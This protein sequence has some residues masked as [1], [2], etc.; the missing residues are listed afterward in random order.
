MQTTVLFG[1]KFNGI[2]WKQEK[3]NVNDL[4]AKFKK[5]RILKDKAKADWIV[6]ASAKSSSRNFESIS[7]FYGMIIDFD[8]TTYTIDELSKVVKMWSHMIHST[9]SHRKARANNY[10]LFIPFKKPISKEKYIKV[11]RYIVSLFPDDSN[12]DACSVKSLQIMYMPS[13]PEKSKDL[14]EIKIR[15]RPVYFEITAEIQFELDEMGD[16]DLGHDDPFDPTDAPEQGERNEFFT[17]FAGRCV[18]IGMSKSQTLSITKGYN[19]TID[20][21]LSNRDIMV[22]VRS[23]Y[24]THKMKSKDSGWGFDELEERIG[25]VKDY[26]KAVE[27]VARSFGKLKHLEIQQLI[28]VI[29][30]KFDEDRSVVKADLNVEVGLSDDLDQW[31]YVMKDN[32]MYNSRICD[33]VKVESF[34]N[35]TGGTPKDF[36]EMISTGS[37]Q[38]ADKFQFNPSEDL[39][40]QSIEVTYV[41][42]YQQVDITPQ[43][44]DVTV[45]L[46]FFEYMFD[47]EGEREVIMDYIAYLVQH[48]GRKVRWMPVIKG[49]SGIGKSTIVHTILTPILGVNNVHNID[50]NTMVGGSFNAWQ[51]DAQLVVLHELQLGTTLKE[52]K[53]LTDSLKSFITDE[54]FMA[55]RKGVD[56]YQVENHANVLSFTNEENAIAITIDERRYCMIRSEAVPRPEDY[57]GDLRTWAKDNVEEMYYFFKNRDLTIFTPNTLPRTQYTDQVKEQSY[58]WPK[59]VL[60][61]CLADRGHVLGTAQAV[62]LAY[63]TRVVQHEAM[64]TRD[65]ERA[66]GLG[67]RGN[68][69][70]MLFKIELESLGFRKM[71][72]NKKDVR[73]YD[74]RVGFQ[75]PVYLTPAGVQSKVGIKAAKREILSTELPDEEM[76][77]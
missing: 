37:L 74:K 44:G 26:A 1:K 72:S 12:A 13:C 2:K 32:V 8:K 24:K 41:N 43:Q 31:V 4:Y 58:L 69:M 38:T 50:N 33:T 73:I 46:E 6:F 40:Y 18:H 23:V 70:N 3:I 71:Q 64:G 54:Y 77:T 29:G 19:S 34:N 62:S 61:S 30:K 28:I 25:S 7:K 20:K 15:R 67:K 55:H 39:I 52:K 75:T 76:W 60:L 57:Y 47:N 35:I 65:A 17:R 48:P 66:A 63:L 11:A 16:E 9:Y 53:Q 27:L 14:F 5:P 45:M 10:H 36:K 21:P 56:P 59:S 49:K 68:N 51:L 22:I 42:T